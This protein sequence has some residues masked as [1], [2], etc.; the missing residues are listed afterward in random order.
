MEIEKKYLIQEEGRSYATQEFFSIAPKVINALLDYTKGKRIRIDS[1]LIT[2]GYLP[3]GKGKELCKSLGLDID[4]EIAEI[5]LRSKN[6]EY[7]LTIKGEGTISREE[8]EIEITEEVFKKNWP[9]TSGKRLKK[10]RAAIRYRDLIA[11]IDF[12]QDRNLITAE[13]ECESEEVAK[14]LIPFGKDVT[15]DKKYKNKNLAR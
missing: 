8:E 12:Y 15:E 4:F 2:Q 3:L 11:E 7:A 6:K 1:L 14:N 13:I 9:L 5:R 10:K